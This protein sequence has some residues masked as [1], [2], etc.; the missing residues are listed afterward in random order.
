[1]ARWAQS[2]HSTPGQHTECS[3]VSPT[4]DGQDYCPHHHDERL[5]GVRVD[6]SSQA[7]CEETGAAGAGPGLG[8]ASLP[9]PHLPPSHM[10]ER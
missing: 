8:A 10:H 1:M 4:F 6:D 2:Q 5:Q 7:P 3:L 9:C